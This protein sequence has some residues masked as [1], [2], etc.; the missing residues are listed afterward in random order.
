MMNLLLA[1]C[2]CVASLMCSEAFKIKENVV[3]KSNQ[4]LQES[5]MEH[6]LS[7]ENVV[8]KSKTNPDQLLQE[9]DMEHLLSFGKAHS[10]MFV[11]SSLILFL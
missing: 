9:S 6:L 3:F 5:D 8:F 1:L 7:S 11:F 2:V 10:T 4:L